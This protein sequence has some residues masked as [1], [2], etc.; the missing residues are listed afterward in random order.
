[1]KPGTSPAKR[2][3]SEEFAKRMGKELRAEANRLVTEAQ[4]QAKQIR[5]VASTFDGRRS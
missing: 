2:E 4:K 3:T 5:K 1:M